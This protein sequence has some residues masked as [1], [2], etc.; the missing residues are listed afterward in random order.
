MSHIVSDPFPQKTREWMWHPH[1]IQ[2]PDQSAHRLNEK[3]VHRVKALGLTQRRATRRMRGVLLLPPQQL[4]VS[5]GT[6]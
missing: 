6:Q 2:L 3:N 4:R 1:S 5:R